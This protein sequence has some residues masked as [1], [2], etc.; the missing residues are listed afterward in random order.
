MGKKSRRHRP[1]K[2]ATD[3]C[4]LVA[5]QEVS[6]PRQDNLNPV[7]PVAVQEQVTTAAEIPVSKMKNSDDDRTSKQD[8][9]VQAKIHRDDYWK[10]IREGSNVGSDPKR[11]TIVLAHFSCI[12]ESKY[13]S[14][15][16]EDK[17]FL[18]TICQST[19]EPSTTRSLAFQVLGWVYLFLLRKAEAAFC[20][21]EAFRT[22]QNASP[23]EKKELGRVAYESE[24]SG[25]RR[26]LK[27][28]LDQQI[29]SLETCSAVVFVSSPM[30]ARRNARNSTG[31][32]IGKFAEN[33]GIF[34][35]EIRLT[36]PNPRDLSCTEAWSKSWNAPTRSTVSF[37]AKRN[38][39]R[40]L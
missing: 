33:R 17:R 10:M 20:F 8:L 6:S 19:L 25:Y 16:K 3:G 9:A 22:L 32:S 27:T 35:W 15:S 7:V 11:A 37:K 13:S 29:V 38:L 1:A 30:T 23:Q 39:P 36:L 5:R 18:K 12:A 4:L 26:R 21:Q 24:L 2:K 34:G 40:R 28:F 14:I 31:T